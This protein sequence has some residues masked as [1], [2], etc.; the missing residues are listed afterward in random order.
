MK[1]ET[2]S[3]DMGVKENGVNIVFPFMSKTTNK[4]F[5]S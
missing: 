1:V 4:M 3:K 5:M 2:M